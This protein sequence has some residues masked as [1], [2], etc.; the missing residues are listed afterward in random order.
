M[1]T[2]AVRSCLE[3]RV[4]HFLQLNGDA[5]ADKVDRKIID[6]IAGTYSAVGPG[7]SADTVVCLNLKSCKLANQSYC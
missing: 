4:R 2:G 3:C 7:A 1:C 6:F 5:A